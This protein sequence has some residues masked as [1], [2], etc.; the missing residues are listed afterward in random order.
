MKRQKCFACLDAKI[1]RDALGD[2]HRKFGVSR[3]AFV[4]R[5]DARKGKKRKLVGYEWIIRGERRREKAVAGKTVRE[6]VVT[7]N[8]KRSEEDSNRQRGA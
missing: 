1:A 2:V 3:A 4:R 7:R 6:S 8:N 5:D